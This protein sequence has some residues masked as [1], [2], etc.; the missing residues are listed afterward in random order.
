MNRNIVSSLVENLFW[1]LPLIFIIT[2]WEFIIPVFIVLVI[3]YILYA[4]LDPLVCFIERLIGIRILSIL[5]VLLMLIA[6]L[7]VGGTYVYSAINNNYN[8]ITEKIINQDPNSKNQGLLDITN[9]SIDVEQRI[10][11]I[12]PESLQVQVKSF[13]EEL[14]QE[15]KKDYIA[16]LIPKYF[17]FNNTIFVFSTAASSLMYIAITVSFIIMLLANAQNFKKG[18]IKMVP[19]RYFEMS[20]KIIDRISEQISSYIRGTFMAATIVG[21]LSIMA[22]QIVCSIFNIPHDYIILVGIIA[23]VFNL[24]PFIG[25]IIGALSGVLLFILSVE[26]P[27]PEALEVATTTI[28]YYHIAAII[29]A[30]GGVQLIDNLV[31]SPLIISDSVGLHPM[32]V[33]IVVLIGGYAMGILGMIIAVPFTAILKVIIEELTWGFRNYLYT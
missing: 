7:Y 30:F 16:N 18:F 10:I 23:G 21:I 24:I 26:P 8:T 12:V 6:P 2:L 5:I 20:L 1:I 9:L 25:P 28:R 22:L 31:T 4:I 3:S 13:F 15:D 29:I 32:F 33:I 11:P 17:N 14:R 27:N 19:N